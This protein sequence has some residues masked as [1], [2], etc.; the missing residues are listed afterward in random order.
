MIT[1]S[2]TLNGLTDLDMIAILEAQNASASTL[3]VNQV[4][5]GTV[6]GNPPMQ[7]FNNVMISWNTEAG[8]RALAAMLQ[9]LTNLKP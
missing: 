3:T 8:F 5:P 2:I 9:T 1:G 6:A 4:Q 7:V